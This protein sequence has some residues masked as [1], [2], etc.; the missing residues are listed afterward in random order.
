MASG[1]TQLR[2]ARSDLTT[3][4]RG[5]THV[6]G[7]GVAAGTIGIFA[8]IAWL[9]AWLREGDAPTLA[10]AL[11]TAALLLPLL[12]GAYAGWVGLH[13]RVALR[14]QGWVPPE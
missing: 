9:T 3:V 6:T 13:L 2:H 10:N 11:V 14:A 12:V 8:T 4:R 7:G 5:L 1:A